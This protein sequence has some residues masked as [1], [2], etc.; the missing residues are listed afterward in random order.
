MLAFVEFY[1]EYNAP[2]FTQGKNCQL[3]L[4][5]LFIKLKW[6]YLTFKSLFTWKSLMMLMWSSTPTLLIVTSS[7]SFCSELSIIRSF[8][9]CDVTVN[10][11]FSKY[12]TTKLVF[13]GELKSTS[14]LSWFL[15]FWVEFRSAEFKKFLLF[16]FLRFV[17]EKTQHV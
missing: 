2:V 16:L 8:S 5:L 11:I 3:A 15:H 10:N 7:C 17:F 13:F 14:H 9:S 4:Y 1:H 6:F 12:F